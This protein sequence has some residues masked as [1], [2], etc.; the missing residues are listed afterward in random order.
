MCFGPVCFC[1]AFL[2]SLESPSA[3]APDWNARITFP[4]IASVVEN[5][6]ASTLSE[7]QVW[8][9]EVSALPV[10]TERYIFL[11]WLITSSHF[12]Y[13]CVLQPGPLYFSSWRQVSWRGLEAPRE[14]LD[15]SLPLLLSE[16][17]FCKLMFSNTWQSETHQLNNLKICVDIKTITSF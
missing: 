11:F 9:R 10:S 12:N 1:T 5:A 7:N 14:G 8:W 2:L 15:P 13:I 16:Q 17:C 3:N 6:V 4:K